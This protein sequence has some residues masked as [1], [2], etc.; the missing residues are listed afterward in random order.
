MQVAF[1]QSIPQ[2]A[3]ITGAMLMIDGG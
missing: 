3:M 1:R 2:S